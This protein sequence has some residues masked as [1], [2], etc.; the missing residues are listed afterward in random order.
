MTFAN[1]GPHYSADELGTRLATFLR[2]QGQTRKIVHASTLLQL[3][4][5]PADMIADARL[6]GFKT[7]VMVPARILRRLGYGAYNSHPGP[8][9]YPGWAP[10]AFAVYDQA[11]TF[12]VTAHKM[13]NNNKV[14]AGPIVG[15]AR[16]PMSPN[17]R[18]TQLQLEALETMSVLLRRLA[19]SLVNDSK[20]P[21]VLPLSWGKPVRTRTEFNRMRELSADLDEEERDRH[22]RALLL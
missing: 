5:L 7:D 6:I 19:P 15:V 8:P 11:P 21:P 17:I 13:T 1:D 3:I 18:S 10:F 12:R 20:P 14:D 4:A 22:R 16:F 9:E 2:L